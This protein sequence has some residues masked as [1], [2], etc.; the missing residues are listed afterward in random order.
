MATHSPY[1][2]RMRARVGLVLLV[3]PLWVAPWTVGRAC[4]ISTVAEMM[5]SRTC[6]SLFSHPQESDLCT[7]P[8]RDY[9]SV[10]GE[11]IFDSAATRL[12]GI[13]VEDG[14]STLDGRPLNGVAITK[15]WPDSPAAL[16]GL[17]GWH[18][19]QMVK[20]VHLE[21]YDLIIA[22]D[23]GRVRDIFD[24]DDSLHDLKPGEIVYFTIVRNRRR[25]QISVS[26]PTPNWAATR[27]EGAQ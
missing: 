18:S 16:A 5:R 27:S 15:V 6:V 7:V 10:G 19:V 17:K 3:T 13:Q 21:I 11:F 24:L 1:A 8:R 20:I 26:L 14:K 12:I 22:I 2:H 9:L 25:E 4:D 23:G